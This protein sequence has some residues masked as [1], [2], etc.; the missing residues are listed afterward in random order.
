[1]QL[2]APLGRRQV[3]RGDDRTCPSFHPG[4][5][6]LRDQMLF[7]PVREG[8]RPGRDLAAAPLSLVQRRL[9]PA[10][11]PDP[12]RTKSAGPRRR[13]ASPSPRHWAPRPPR[14]RLRPRRPR[15]GRLP[16]PPTQPRRTQRAALSPRSQARSLPGAPQEKGE[17]LPGRGRGKSQDHGKSHSPCFWGPGDAFPGRLPHIQVWPHPG[18]AGAMNQRLDLT[19]HPPTPASSRPRGPHRGPPDKGLGGESAVPPRGY[20]TCPTLPLRGPSRPA[21]TQTP[22]GGVP[23]KV[24]TKGRQLGELVNYV[25][26]VNTIFTGEKP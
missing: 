7:Q 14:T 6:R 25:G 15:G 20:Q 17:E 8:T 3:T 23:R 10:Q 26:L 1:M 24:I 9:P 11:S 18:V 12:P 21:A 13:R 22:F 5:W 2:Q 16:H 19:P 4:G